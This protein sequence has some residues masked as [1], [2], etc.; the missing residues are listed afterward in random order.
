MRLQA[1]LPK[2][3]HFLV[4]ENLR[5]GSEKGLAQGRPRRTPALK[6]ARGAPMNQ[7]EAMSAHPCTGPDGGLLSAM[8]EIQSYRS[9]FGGCLAVT[10][11]TNSKLLKGE[12]SDLSSY[13]GCNPL[14]QPFR[15]F[16]LPKSV[17][18]IAFGCANKSSMASSDPGCMWPKVILG[19]ARQRSV[20]PTKARLNGSLDS[21]PTLANARLNMEKSPQLLG[22]EPVVS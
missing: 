8:R 6:R 2:S 9:C 12:A 10:C 5:T 1:E 7:K 13:R 14:P 21:S 15:P 20:R 11:T 22:L 3:G 17:V 16:S 18:R 4:Q 19:A